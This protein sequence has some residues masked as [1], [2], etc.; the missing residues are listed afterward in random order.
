MYPYD[1]FRICRKCAINHIENCPDCLG[2]GQIYRPIASGQH[3]RPVLAKE[4]HDSV[5]PE[6]G[7]VP[8]PTCKSTPLGVENVT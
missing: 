8:C 7:W 1:P 3:R 4:A 6:C 5:F 2:F